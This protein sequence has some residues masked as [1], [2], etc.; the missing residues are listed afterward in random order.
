MKLL[1]M[2]FLSS[3][4][5][6]LKKQAAASPFLFL[7]VFFLI[8]PLSTSRSLLSTA[9]DHH[10]LSPF[11]HSPVRIALLSRRSQSSFTAHLFEVVF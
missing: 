2:S 1:P 11:S 7:I 5:L 6:L 10:F 3:V 4:L 9:V 8:L